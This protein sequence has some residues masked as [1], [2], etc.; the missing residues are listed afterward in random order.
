MAIPKTIIQTFKTDK[1]PLITKWHIRQ[2]KKRNP[3]YDYQFYDDD[4]ID[5]F[6]LDEFGNDIYTLFKKIN[7]GAAMADFFRYAILYRKGGI[8]L[9]IDSRITRPIGEFIL[10]SDKAVITLEGNLKFYVQYALFYEPEHVFL[11][12]T[13]DIVIRNLKEN[14]YPYNTHQ[15]TGPSAY[16]EAINSV[17]KESTDLYRELSFDYANNVEFSYPMSKLFLYGISRKNH[18]KKQTQLT[19]V[20]GEKV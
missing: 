17:K 19:P 4:R 18:W 15:M 6:I 5:A 9:D 10:P 8:Y 14:K 1:L 11:E 13:L 2:L 7:I 20:I 16:T 12:K 3:D